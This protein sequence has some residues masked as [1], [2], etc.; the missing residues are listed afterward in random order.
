MQLELD[1]IG[2]GEALEE[3]RECPRLRRL[4]DDP[5]QVCRHLQRA[6]PELVD[7][8]EQVGR[9]RLEPVAQPVGPEVERVVV[10]AVAERADAHQ[11]LGRL[12][13]VDLDLDPAGAREVEDR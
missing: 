6:E 8:L 13:D 7:R 12:G 2:R 5:E 4:E 9:H 11:H 1:R 3:G 10:G